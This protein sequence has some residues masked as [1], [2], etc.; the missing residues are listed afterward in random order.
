MWMWFCRSIPSN[1]DPEFI[2]LKKIFV[3]NTGMTE[4]LEPLLQPNENRHVLFPIQ[5]PLLYKQ[6]KDATATFWRPEEID[7]S[8]D[9]N[10]WEK[11]SGN[12][13]RFI[14]YVLAFFAAS[15]GIVMEN[16]VE[17]F[18]SDIQIPEARA[19]LFL[20]DIY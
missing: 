9:K 14:K 13:R 8:K 20:S 2:I 1:W 15:D 12:E 7:L 11:L 6:Y 16:L 5:Y 19:F 10:D 17:R 18:M 4:Y 3:L